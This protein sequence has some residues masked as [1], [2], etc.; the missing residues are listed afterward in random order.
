MYKRLLSYSLG[1]LMNPSSTARIWLIASIVI[2]IIIICF[3]SVAFNQ[4]PPLRQAQINI[5]LIFGITSS[6]SLLFSVLSISI[7]KNKF[8]ALVSFILCPNPLIWV[9]GLYSLQYRKSAFLILVAY[10]LSY[11]LI[12]HSGLIKWAP[13]KHLTRRWTGP[14]YSCP[15]LGRACFHLVL[16]SMLAV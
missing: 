5:F 11:F 13:K 14:L 3:L 7:F 6:V 9:G 10:P 12:V 16:M 4:N 1:A 15:Q 8:S 2:N